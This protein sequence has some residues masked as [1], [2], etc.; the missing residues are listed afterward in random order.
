MEGS[1]FHAISRNSAPFLAHLAA[2]WTNAW[3][4]V[5]SAGEQVMSRSPAEA[6]RQASSATNRAGAVIPIP[7]GEK[8]FGPNGPGARPRY[9][10]LSRPGSA[11]L[12]RSAA[13]LRYSALI[14]G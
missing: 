8:I 2:S 4:T 14:D 1:V 6:E 13:S 3:E 10:N 9:P 7:F 11:Q 5:P 12:H